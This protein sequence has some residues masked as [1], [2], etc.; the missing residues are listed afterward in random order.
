MKLPSEVSFIDLHTHS[1]KEESDVFQIVNLF[2]EQMDQLFNNKNPFSAY[3]IGWHPWYLKRNQIEV[4]MEMI[5]RVSTNDAIVAIGECGLDLLCDPTIPLQLTVFK[6]HALI[7][8]V[9]KKPLIIHC[10]R[11]FNELIRLKKEIMPSVPW[12]IHGFNANLTIGKELIRHGFYFSLGKALLDETS[13]AAKLLPE[14]AT[15]HLFLETDDSDKSIET[16]YRQAALLT[17]VDVEE[18][19]KRMVAN[20]YTSFNIR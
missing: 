2:P 19:R 10:V 4:T 16:I 7:A 15:D 18:L 9:V 1:L 6:E 11:A 8:E 12:I 13:N 20:Y 14:M 3:S 5:S 17:K